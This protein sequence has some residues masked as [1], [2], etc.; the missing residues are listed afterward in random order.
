MK[1]VTFKN[2]TD[3]Q[4]NAIKVLLG[5]A[6]EIEE[7]AE[8]EKDLP[9]FPLAGDNYYFSYSDGEIGDKLY[10][11]T[12]HNDIDRVSMGNCFRTEEEA[13]F[14]IERLKVLQEMKRF[15]EPKDYKWNGI[16]NHHYIYGV[17]NNTNTIKVGYIWTC[18]SND[19]YFKSEKD[20]KACVEAVGEDRI[21]KYYLRIEEENNDTDN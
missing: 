16:N 8:E 3:E 1:D 5:D 2:L 6:C 13:K 18:K 12:S 21:K 10:S 7:Q 9:S 19:I 15:E 14:E 17:L 4:I 11:P 20:V